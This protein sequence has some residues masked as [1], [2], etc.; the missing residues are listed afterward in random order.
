MIGICQNAPWYRNNCYSAIVFEDIHTFEKYWC[1]TN[2]TI[3]NWWR[4]QANV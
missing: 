1:H 3:T 2:D 4:G